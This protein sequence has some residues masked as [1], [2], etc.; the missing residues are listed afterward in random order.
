MTLN[1]AEIWTDCLNFWGQAWW[2]EVFT[3]GPKCTYYFGPFA[4]R[5][6]ARLAISGYVEDL[7]SESAQ[8]IHTQIEQCKPR[9]LT[10]DCED[11]A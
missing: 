10:I 8:V 1:L 4:D 2:V 3:I 7:E 11:A 5:Q 6:Q 9:R